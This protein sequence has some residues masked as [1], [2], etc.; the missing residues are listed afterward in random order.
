MNKEP[1]V[2]FLVLLSAWLV[3][4]SVARAE[5]VSLE[6]DAGV[7]GWR[8]VLDGV[9]GGRSTGRVFQPEA[10]ILRFSGELSLENNGGF[11]QMQTTV[12]EGS[13]KD[14]VGIETMVRG[15]GWT[16]QFDVRCSDIRMMA[17][18][19]QAEFHTREGE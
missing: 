19:F 2:R 3:I 8:T 1:R 15:D 17:G 12:P 7:S 9:M 11:S 10:R 6:F 16:Y 5:P 4:A 13:L 18:S 14:A